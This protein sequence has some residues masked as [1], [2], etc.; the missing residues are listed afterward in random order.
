MSIRGVE[1]GPHRLRLHANT[2]PPKLSRGGVKDID[3]TSVADEIC[4][5]SPLFLY[6]SDKGIEMETPRPERMADATASTQLREALE[7]K[8]IA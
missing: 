8:I 6:C 4:G 7:V 2:L 3:G 1:L 5:G